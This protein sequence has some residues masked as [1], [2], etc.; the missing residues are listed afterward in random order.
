[1]YVHV[2]D[3]WYG[4]IH[5][6]PHH[7]Y[8]A[9]EFVCAWWLPVL[10]RRSMLFYQENSEPAVAQ[11]T[12]PIRLSVRS[13]LI[14]YLKPICVFWAGFAILMS[15]LHGP[16]VKPDQAL[17]FWLSDI[18]FFMVSC[19]VLLLLKKVAWASA[20]YRKRLAGSDGLPPHLVAI[21]VQDEDDPMCER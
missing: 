9:T 3:H 17:R 10:P 5:V 1:M 11:L 2:S 18:A 12:F 4:R 16:K 19:L 7:C 8:V 20:A 13:I 6:I 21:L 14:A 15:C